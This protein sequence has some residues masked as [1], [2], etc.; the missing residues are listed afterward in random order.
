MAA[1]AM[2]VDK[3]CVAA[4]DAL[5]ASKKLVNQIVDQVVVIFQSMGLLITNL[6]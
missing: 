2:V 1:A 3:D 6:V 4:I 5:L